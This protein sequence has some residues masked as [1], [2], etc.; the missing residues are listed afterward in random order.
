FQAQPDGGLDGFV[1]KVRADG[2]PELM[3][4]VGGKTTEQ[5]V[6]IA[7]RGMAT[8]FSGWSNSPTFLALNALQGRDGGYETVV[9]K[10][11]EAA[12]PTVGTPPSS[13]KRRT[14]SPACRP[15]GAACC[16]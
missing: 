12:P 10:L 9:G 7:N 1:G 13:S 14:S 16:E 4:F 3:S 11:C 15:A 5:V 8:W 6:S 2:T